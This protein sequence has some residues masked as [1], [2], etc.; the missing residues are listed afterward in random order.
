MRERPLLEQMLHVMAVG[1]LLVEI[2]VLPPV[3]VMGMDRKQIADTLH[4]I[5]SDKYMELKDKSK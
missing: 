1:G 4:K 2:T 5:I 3:P